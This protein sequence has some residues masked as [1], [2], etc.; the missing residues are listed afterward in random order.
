MS[1][2]LES[3]ILNVNTRIKELPMLKIIDIGL[4]QCQQCGG[5]KKRPG[6]EFQSYGFQNLPEAEKT[7]TGLRV[8]MNVLRWREQTFLCL[9]HFAQHLQHMIDDV[10][11]Q[12]LWETHKRAEIEPTFINTTYEQA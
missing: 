11:G 1:H 5:R 9:K 10:S 7:E 6:V 4:V 12:L 8:K 3:E 2:E